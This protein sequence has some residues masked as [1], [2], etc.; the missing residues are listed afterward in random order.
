MNGLIKIDFAKLGVLNRRRRAA[1]VLGLTLDGSRLDGTVPVGHGL[2]RV[3]LAL[4]VTGD[5]LG[6][7][8]IVVDDQHAAHGARVGGDAAFQPRGPEEFSES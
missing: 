6:D 4:E 2:D 5:D 8:R 3:A 7:G 1:S